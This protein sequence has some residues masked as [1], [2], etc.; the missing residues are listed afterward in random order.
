MGLADQKIVI[1]GGGSGIGA[2]IARSLAAAGA[3]VVIAGRDLEKLKD[4][5]A[6]HP[7]RLIPIS[8][9]VAN[10]E[11][12]A[13]LFVQAVEKLGRIDVLVNAAGINVPQRM[14]HNLD[15]ADWDRMMDINATGVF[16]C[17]RAALP[18]MRERKSGTIINISSVAGVRAAALGGV[19]YNASKFAAT[20]LGIS[21]GDEEK[22]NG[23]RVTNIY[24]GEVDTPI[25]KQRP[26]AVTEEHRARMLL[27]EDVAA[28]V[29]MVIEL[30]PRA[31]I[32]EL[33][34]IPLY[35]SFV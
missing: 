23:I 16:N 31:R 5:A 24:P 28:A 7:D 15:P 13:Q 8:A 20:G 12:V 11:S 29:K 34:I 10:R 3:T 22:A 27:P 21:A 18:A 35:Q 30:P 2:G 14:M 4:V 25:L 33:T 32:P 9:D 17:M 1:T 6:S 26:T 19:G